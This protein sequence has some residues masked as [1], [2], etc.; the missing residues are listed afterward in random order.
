M[1]IVPTRSREIQLFA[2]R[3]DFKSGVRAGVNGTR[4]SLLM[5]IAMTVRAASSRFSALCRNR[6]SLPK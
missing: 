2:L 6:Q 5:A 4:V 3:E 1:A